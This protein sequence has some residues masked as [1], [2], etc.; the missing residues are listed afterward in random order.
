M[1]T[2]PKYIAG[3][4]TSDLRKALKVPCITSSK[5]TVQGAAKVSQPCKTVKKLNSQH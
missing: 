4:E 5:T 1:K 2:S 3:P